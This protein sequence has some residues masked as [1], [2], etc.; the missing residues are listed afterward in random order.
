M[1]K[2]ECEDCKYY[3][4]CKCGTKPDGSDNIVYVCDLEEC[5]YAKEE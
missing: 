5:A 3:M 4:P 1:K 2:P